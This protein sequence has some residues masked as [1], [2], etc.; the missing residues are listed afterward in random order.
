MEFKEIN[1][2][3]IN[4]FS[5]NENTDEKGVYLALMNVSSILNSIKFTNRIE[6]EELNNTKQPKK[7]FSDNTDYYQR[8]LNDIRTKSLIEFIIIQI[9]NSLDNNLFII[10]FPT[11]FILS[12]Y[13]SDIDNL[14]VYK[15]SISEY[16]VEKENKNEFNDVF[17]QNLGVYV[18]NNK[19]TF[20]ELDLILVVDGQHR[21]AALKAIFYTLKRIKGEKLNLKLN[22]PIIELLNFTEKKLIEFRFENDQILEMFDNFQISCTVLIDFDVWEQGKVFANVNFNQKPVNKSLYYDI[23]GSF[24]EPDKNDI[25]LAH[26][27][28]F[29]LNKDSKSALQGKIKMLG[30]GEG[31]ISQAFLCDSFIGFLRKGGIWYNIATNFTL[32]KKDET[33]KIEK[34]LI[35]Y[36]RAIA[37]KFGYKDNGENYFWPSERD[38]ISTFDSILHKT[39]G[40]GAMIRLIPFFFK[41]IENKIDDDI[42]NITSLISDVFNAHLNIESLKKIHPNETTALIEKKITG[43]YYFSKKNG[44]FS[45]GAGLGLQMK[46]YRILA[47]DFGLEK[48]NDKN[49]HYNVIKL[50]LLNN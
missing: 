30:T 37:I 46:L 33:E 17:E 13:K 49:G 41:K 5:S 44:V 11:S 34:F 42:D 21:L 47:E 16:F 50:D 39:T 12:I 4:Q 15:K 2:N 24:P 23:F 36:F 45:G 32:D 25:Y 19:I 29:N 10:P 31:F 22:D 20:P 48:E 8:L 43:Q 28:C 35:S 1:I 40:L 38:S 27:W 26:R 7:Y 3:K 6:S 18:E 9:K 14:D